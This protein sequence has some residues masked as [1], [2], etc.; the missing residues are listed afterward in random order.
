[1]LLSYCL[2]L[3]HLF[4]N[5]P[6]FPALVPTFLREK[7]RQSPPLARKPRFRSRV[8]KLMKAA[9]ICRVLSTIS[10]SLCRNVP[11]QR[12]F[13]RK[14]CLFREEEIGVRR[15]HTRPFRTIG[16]INRGAANAAPLSAP[17]NTPASMLFSYFFSLVKSSLPPFSRTTISV[18]SGK[19]PSR[20]L[21]LSGSRRSCWMARLRGRAP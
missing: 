4:L 21:R 7:L 14:P 1:M 18:P 13:E 12:R 9:L 2:V 5:V 15:F 17:G 10:T 6:L 11:A 8:P 20:S 16:A 3:P 19:S